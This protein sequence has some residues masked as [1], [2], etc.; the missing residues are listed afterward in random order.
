MFFSFKW[1]KTILPLLAPT[2]EKKFLKNAQVP[3][4]WNKSFRRPCREVLVIPFAFVSNAKPFVQP[5][6]EASSC[7][8]NNGCARWFPQEIA[9]MVA[10]AQDE[11][12]RRREGAAAVAERLRKPGRL[13]RSVR[14]V[15]GNGLVL[16]LFRCSFFPFFCQKPNNA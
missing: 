12:K 3:P 4:P 11:E 10:A 2:P 1:E 16:K 8:T 13:S 7:G 15:S 5:G 9:A 14:R 6:S